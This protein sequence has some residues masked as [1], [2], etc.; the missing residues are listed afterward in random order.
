MINRL[1]SILAEEYGSTERLLSTVDKLYRAQS[2]QQLEEFVNTVFEKDAADVPGI[3]IDGTSA[4]HLDSSISH[5]A[6]SFLHYIRTRSEFAIEDGFSAEG[7][8]LRNL[9]TRL[10]EFFGRSRMK[11]LSKHYVE[12]ASLV[13]LDSEA[14]GKLAAEIHE[15]VEVTDSGSLSNALMDFGQH[16]PEFEAASNALSQSLRVLY[17]EKAQ[18]NAALL[19]QIQELRASC[20][21]PASIAETWS[22]Q[23][24]VAETI[25]LR[26]RNTLLDA[27]PHYPGLFACLDHKM[28][29]GLDAVD[30]AD[31]STSEVR[32]LLRWF[33]TEDFSTETLRRTM[34]PVNPLLLATCLA[35]VARGASDPVLLRGYISGT[36]LTDELESNLLEAPN[37]SDLPKILDLE[38]SYVLAIEILGTELLR[39]YTFR[40]VTPKRSHEIWAGWL[41]VNPQ[42]QVSEECSIIG[43][44]TAL[45]YGKSINAAIHAYLQRC[46]AALVT[47]TDEVNQILATTSSSN[48]LR[49]E[50]L[51]RRDLLDRLVRRAERLY[52]WNPHEIAARM[53]EEIFGIAHPDLSVPQEFNFPHELMHAL[54]E[55][56]GR[57]RN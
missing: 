39:K 54:V 52:L 3:W 20:E 40:S 23:R 28:R 48:A 46:K 5:D 45:R 12:K 35:L 10:E 2:D 25:D 6:A 11:Q 44:K 37:I 56:L 21:I 9:A 34:A 55:L 53:G 50:V 33:R 18:R 17:E 14:L 36:L 8:L 38:E 16:H 32:E 47:A 7:E 26:S 4:T 31:Y 30:V 24:V 57:K 15:T 27:V 29:Q 13:L 43:W 41:V 49:A 51:T 22:S 19:R 1:K 42:Y